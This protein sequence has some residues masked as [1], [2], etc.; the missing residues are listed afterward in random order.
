MVLPAY[1]SHGR[2]ALL[3]A[4]F[5]GDGCRFDAQIANGMKPQS[6]YFSIDKND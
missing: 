2:R 5:G 1:A 4:S 6:L 3:S